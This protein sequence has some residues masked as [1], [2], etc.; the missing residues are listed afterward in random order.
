FGSDLFAR[1]E[2]LPSLEQLLHVL[3]E[4]RRREVFP[5]FSQRADFLN[6]GFRLKY[7]RL[8]PEA[9]LNSE[10]VIGMDGEELVIRL[11][12]RL[13]VVSP[14][15]QPTELQHGICGSLPHRQQQGFGFPKSARLRQ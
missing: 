11:Q 2:R 4:N 9:L 6:Q 10:G 1:L 8:D 12:R 14:L 15:V 3:Q 5:E 13:Q 7:A